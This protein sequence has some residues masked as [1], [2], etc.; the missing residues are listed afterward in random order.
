MK[1]L[2]PLTLRVAV[3]AATLLLAAC[4][5]ETASPDN[6]VHPRP[7]STAERQT[8]SSAND[9]AYQAFGTLQQAEPDSNI[10]ISPL[11]ISAALTMAYNGAAGSTKAAMKQTLGFQPMTDLEINQ[12]YQ[13]LFAL[14][15]G[16]DSRVQFTAANAIWYKQGM[17]L[18]APFVQTNQT[19]FG[20]T[21]QPARFGDP[22]VATAINGWAS[23]NTQGKIPSIVGATTP[24]D[25]LYLLNAIYFRGT[26][27][28]QFNPQLTR[29]APF[30]QANGSTSQANFMTLLNGKYLYYADSQQTVVDLP[31]G[32]RQFS[33]TLVTPA[34]TNT[35]ARVA[36]RLSSAQLGTWLAA[37]D[38]SS[39]ELHLPK[40][41]LAYEKE[42]RESLTQLGMGVAFANADFSQ[43]FAGGVSGLSI[44][45][46][47]H[48]TFL[49]VN[50]EGTEAAAV[51]AVGIGT[52]SVPPSLWLN[53]PFIFLIREK[54][55]NAILFIG[56]LTNP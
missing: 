10:F 24:D 54:S 40:F 45:A 21:V 37:A 33:M 43:L 26:W 18:A 56:Q 23:A 15:G 1:P 47:K 38:T 48:K 34:G 16:L 27:T 42:L 20:A 49:D 8:L 41:R 55:S 36:S 2:L 51:T 22:A 53:R 50:E 12:S 19:Y 32:N 17:Q 31:Y 46:V 28:Y 5:K 30:Y 29:P 52:T 25:V 39:L 11:S 13:S 35:L 9:F 7:L 14:L 6:T 4:Q 3:A 44:T